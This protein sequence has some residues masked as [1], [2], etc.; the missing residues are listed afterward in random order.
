MIKMKTCAI[1]GCDQKVSARGWCSTHYQRWQRHGDPSV[2]IRIWGS[3]T[4]RLNRYVDRSTGP[5]GCHLW[6][7]STNPN[8]YGQI[9]V[10]GRL[11]LAHRAAYE[12][13][14]APIP[15]G[16]VIDHRCGT[17][18]C[19]NPKHLRACTQKQNME[20]RRGPSRINRSGVRGVYWHSNTEK[21]LASVTHNGK[22]HFAGLFETVAEAE[23]AVIAARLALFTHND[24][25]RA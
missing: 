9:S 3:V 11:Q 15:T 16:Y 18:A 19:V 14:V 22:T 8:G 20:N 17:P 24:A 7:R 25:D 6:T 1:D 23:D 21:W 12:A 4:D 5:D 2:Q 10:D 13:A